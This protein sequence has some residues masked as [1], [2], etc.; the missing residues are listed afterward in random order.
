M[1][2]YAFM[3]RAFIAGIII[4]IIAPLIGNFIIL[5]RFSQIGDTLSH[6]AILGVAIGLLI[7]FNPLFG[8]LLST[9]L[10][11]ILLERIRKGFKGFAEIS[12]SII[13]MASLGLSAIIFSRLKSS[14]NV[15]N[16]LFGSIVAISKND[17]LIIL[18]IAIPTIFITYLLRKELLY[19]C[20]DEDGAYVSGINVKL[21]NLILNILVALV[22]GISI[23]IVGGFLISA[24]LVV[25]GAIA[26]KLVTN[27]S[28]LQIFSI[29]I[30]LFSVISGIIISFYLNISPGGSIVIIFTILFIIAEFYK[31]RM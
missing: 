29:I 27:F 6:S 13:T 17:I 28:R 20:F 23:R 18:S 26:M 14:A 31:K 3:Q 15:M 1:L 7:G 22:V 24:L 21:L 2:Q 25:P 9:V 4:A 10:F 19:I 8:A 5:K 12:L 30:S 16:Y 11:A